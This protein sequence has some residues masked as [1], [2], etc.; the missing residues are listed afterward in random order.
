[1]QKKLKNWTYKR[2]W[3]RTRERKKKKK[4]E[5]NRER[6]RE[7]EWE[8][9]RKGE[10]P[11]SGKIIKISSLADPHTKPCSVQQALNFVE[12]NRQAG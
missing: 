2:E 7:R 10:A 5:R 6:E 3:E 11:E 8:R 4:R 1:M 9:E 12:S